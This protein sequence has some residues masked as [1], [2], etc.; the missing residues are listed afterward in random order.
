MVPTCRMLGSMWSFVS[1]SSRVPIVILSSCY[2]EE[3]HMSSQH[4]CWFPSGSLVTSH[5]QK[6]VSRWIGDSKFPLD[7]NIFCRAHSRFTPIVV[8]V[9]IV[10]ARLRVTEKEELDRFLKGFG[11][12]SA[13]CQEKI[14]PPSVKAGYTYKELFLV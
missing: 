11:T 4:P 10:N 5:L 2:S 14:R 12:T 7:V 1:R 9:R 8:V 6:H 3:F 13:I